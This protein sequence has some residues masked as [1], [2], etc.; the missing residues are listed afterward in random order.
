MNIVHV[1]DA[2]AACR[3][4][5]IALVDGRR[6]LTFAGLDAASRWAALQLAGAGTGADDRALVFCPMSVDLYV[7]LLGLFRIGAIAVFVDPSAGRDQIAACCDRLK[8]RAFV[9]TH[10]AHLLRLISKAI[11]RIP[12]KLAIAGGI[13]GT[14]AVTHSLPSDIP[15]VERNIEPRHTTSPA[16]ITFTSGSTGRPNAVVRTHGFLLAQHEILARD[17][18]LR[19]GEVD[20]A[21]LPVFVL[22]NLASGL[23][24]VIPD[25]DVRTPGLADPARLLRWT[26]RTRPVRTAASPAL[27][28]RLAEHLITTGQRLEMDRVFTG[29][30]PV[31]LA[32]MD[33]LAAVAPHATITA[34]YGSSEAEPIACL[35]REEITAHDRLQ[36]RSGAGV[37][38]GT[39]VS[40]IEV[41]VIPDAWGKP[42][43]PYDVDTFAARALPSG[44]S[45]EI[46]VSGV[47]VLTGY[48]DGV[49][50]ERTKIRAGDQTWHRTGDAGYLDAS[51]R[52]W[53][54]G[55]CR[56]RLEDAR[57]T[58]YPFAVECAAMDL[59][60]V[61]RTALVQHRGRRVLLVQLRTPGR[62]AS[63]RELGR[64]LDWAHLD[65][66]REVD[67]IPMDRRHNAKIDYPALREMLGS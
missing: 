36:M 64:R 13:P 12:V 59:A 38:A 22:A 40:S 50:D 58:L 35:R 63:L 49:G 34:V 52:I 61:H 37:L 45:G 14:P 44:C 62:D 21:T 56:A 6:S 5:Q 27:L 66:L 25:V 54:L 46:V 15:S 57:G 51:G 7:T 60:A 16:L 26:K 30:A 23:T 32:L 53:L 8:P 1:L 41:Q 17:L 11:A 9:A 3:P 28:E 48:L 39:P 65:E 20:L 10:R 67:R 47:H 42:L 19:A 33:R 29:G 24:S 31:S 18:A 55:R 43:G 4:H 2:Q